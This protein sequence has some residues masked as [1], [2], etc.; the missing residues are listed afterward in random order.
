MKRER[1]AWIVSVVLLAVLAL[2]LPGTMAARDDDYVFVR[3]I[4]DLHRQIMAN[5]V[6]DVDDEKLKQKAIEGMMSELDPFSVY[7]PPAQQTEF[8][9]MLEGTFKGVGIELA[10]L[11]DGRVQV[12]SPIEG[13][14][15]FTAGVMAGDI[16]TKVNG[17]TLDLSMRLPEVIN[18]IKGQAGTTVKLTVKHATGEEVEL[19]M[20]RKEI[21][22][23]TVKGFQR[24]GDDS[25]DYYVVD[26]PKIAY[27]RITQFTENTYPGIHDVLVGSPGKPG[28]ADTGMQGL[29]LDLR[30]NPGGM[31]DQARKIINMFV[32][33]GTLILQ[34]KGRK[35][36]ETLKADATDKLP[37]F[38]LIILVNEHSASASEIVSGS[39]MDNKR[40]LVVG[41]RTYGKG[42]VQQLIN[43][44]DN[45]G[46][47]KLTMAY[48]YLPSGRLVHRTKDATDWGVDPQIVVPMDDIAQRAIVEEHVNQEIVRRPLVKPTTPAN[49]PAAAATAPT[50]APTTQ[51]N[52]VQLQQAVNTMVGMIILG[53]ATTAP[54]IPPQAAAI[55]LPVSPA[56]EVA[57][58]APGNI[59]SPVTRPSPDIAPPPTGPTPEMTPPAITAPPDAAPPT[60][61]QPPAVSPAQPPATQP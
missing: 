59:E 1:I 26:N 3:T 34:T 18:K 6:V 43:L 32:P 54:A 31:L 19:T 58:T 35:V 46:E 44:D 41:T 53:H 60:P 25:W 45:N 39:L 27:I 36:A 12:I 10:Q 61:A 20:E 28:L 51:P 55:P 33:D 22:V 7:V 13:S 17:D 49:A 38:P 30:F 56:P 23:P 52:D 37:N 42:S 57:P 21:S 50:T 14:P 15:A 11:P 47:L 9:T 29:I 48:Y 5:Y 8:D 40:A 16:L 4:I 2:R 24:N